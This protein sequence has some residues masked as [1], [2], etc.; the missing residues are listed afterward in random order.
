[1]K[2]F[3]V[4]GT[5]TIKIQRST[6]RST[7]RSTG[8]SNGPRVCSQLSASTTRRPQ[9]FHPHAPPN[10]FGLLAGSDFKT[11]AFVKVEGGRFQ[12][13]FFALNQAMAERFQTRMWSWALPLEGRLPKFPQCACCFAKFVL[14]QQ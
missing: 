9:R 1:M 10:R 3:T 7:G 8:R 6:E 4:H 14:E 12:A 11:K 13:R 2:K 5:I